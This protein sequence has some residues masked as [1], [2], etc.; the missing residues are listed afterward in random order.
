MLT[1]IFLLQVSSSHSN[2]LNSASDLL[3]L[4]ENSILNILDKLDF[5]EL[6]LV[7]D[8]GPRLAELVRDHYM[9]GKYHIDKLVVIVY[10]CSTTRLEKDAL[11]LCGFQT[12]L[13]FTR[14]YGDLIQNLYYYPE[15]RAFKPEKIDSMN[16]HIEQYCSKTVSILH[17][18]DPT[19]HFIG[20]PKQMFPLDILARNKNLRKFDRVTELLIY[21][22]NNSIHL[23]LDQIYP[24]LEILFF[25]S[26]IDVNNLK[27]L[28]RP[29]EHLKRVMLYT[30]VPIKGGSAI[31]QF[32]K[33]NPQLTSLGFD[34]SPD[35]KLLQFISKELQGLEGIEFPYSADAISGSMAQKIH[36][37]NVVDFSILLKTTDHDNHEIPFTFEQLKSI[38][39]DNKYFTE[40]VRHLIEQ[41]KNLTT[42]AIP[43]LYEKDDVVRVVATVR[44]LPLL[45]KLFIQWGL[46]FDLVK[47]L[48]EIENFHDNLKTITFVNSKLYHIL[49]TLPTN[50]KLVENKDSRDKTYTIVRD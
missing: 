22:Y 7:A 2:E 39:V 40:P 34:K 47:T 24:M 25:N 37:P 29:Y 41:N 18:V 38:S 10:D 9:I 32:F 11:I 45:K 6:V 35:M 26:E 21:H 4:D 16:Q 33:L 27:S 46:T 28:A 43:Q 15:K 31:H 36:F 49:P 14:M 44:R 20:E 8:A 19:A 23:E 42:L 3:N 17:L 5:N 30:P 50:W 13:R 12:F 1:K 48:S